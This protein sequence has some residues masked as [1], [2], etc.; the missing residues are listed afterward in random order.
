M[1]LWT[2]QPLEVWEQLQRHG[3]LRVD[4]TRMEYVPDCYR[5]LTSQ[6]VQR[7]HGYPGTL[8]WWS[9]CEKPDLRWVRHGRP[10]GTRQVRIELEA[11]DDSSLA[12]RLWAWDVVYGCNYLSASQP[13]H[14]AWMA[15]MRSEVPD[16]D[17]YPLPEPWQ[18]A[19]EETWLRLFD[20]HLPPHSWDLEV[21]GPNE[22]WEAVVGELRLTD[23]RAV[24]HFI[25]ASRW[26]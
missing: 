13:E 10:R 7:I 8:P 21:Y 12:F 17:L 11:A 3:A 15:A 1:R 25:G 4:E 14:D 26:H 20:P 22:H 23:V 5:W 9:Y 18:T 24:T 19:L 6:L 2:V 16:E